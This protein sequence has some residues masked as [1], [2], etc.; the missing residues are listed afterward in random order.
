MSAITDVVSVI[1]ANAPIFQKPG[2]VS[3]R[4]GYTTVNGWPTTNVAI[5]V[6]VAQGADAPALP[7]TLNGIPVEVRTADDVEQLR[8]NNPEKYLAVAQ[9][10]PEF[11]GGAFPELIADG[12]TARAELQA[13]ID[14]LLRGPAKTA[15]DYTGPDGVSLTARTGK[16]A[17]ICHVSPDAGWPTLKTFLQGVKQTLTVAMYDF[18]SGHI[19]DTVTAAMPGKGLFELV[20][21][22]P[23]KNPTADQD[24]TETVSDLSDALTD[25][26]E[27][28][29]ALV[30]ANNPLPKYIFPSAYHIKVAVRDSK[31]V[32][33]SSGNWNNSN[34]PDINPT[35]TPADSDQA[36][37]RK[38]DRDWHVVIDDADIAQQYEAYIKHDY[39]VATDTATQAGTRGLTSPV[40]QVPDL[41]R[42]GPARVFEFHAP[43]EI[44]GEDVTI[45]PL[46]TPDPESYRPHMLALIK[47][48]QQRLY[49]QLQYI[50]PPN[51]DQ[52]GDFKELLDAV[53]DRIAAGIDVKLILSQWQT[54]QGWLE[55]LQS[56]GFDLSHVKIQNSVHNKGFIIDDDTAVLGS[57][58][59]SGDGVLRNRDASVIIKNKNA[60]AYYAD[61]FMHDWN[62]IA[63][64]TKN[65]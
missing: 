62:H 50:H 60:A 48:A 15:I 26:F 14:T 22:H 40:V 36:T 17:L 3:V 30:R 23:A 2:I 31:A 29:W 34:Q 28:A 38:S 42:G 65:G 43:L 16:I 53:I 13:P 57:Q 46:L 51:E 19:L 5:V 8:A 1:N 6:I 20:L 61:I 21:D 4:P 35:V 64:K 47:S 55:R 32:W 52:D 37:A 10:E 54:T 49:I 44:T 58:N 24:D 56:A 7:D 12:N 9:K 33:V 18:T 27:Q 11:R 63:S 25:K 39:D 41:L 45:T 59:W